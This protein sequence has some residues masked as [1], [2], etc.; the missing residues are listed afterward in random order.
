[1]ARIRV[2]APK[3]ARFFL[4]AGGVSL[5]VSIFMWFPVTAW[6]K[7][8]SAM[9]CGELWYA[10][11][12]IYAAKGYCF[13]TQRARQVFGPRC[14]PPYGRLSGSEQ[15]EVNLIRSFERRRG[16]GRGGTPTPPAVVPPA[17]GQTCDQLWYARNAI[18]AAKGYCFQTAKARRVFGPGCF[19]PYGKLTP[20]EQRRVDAI[21]RQEGLM[22]C[23]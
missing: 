18:Y 22:G 7:P 17:A 12:A 23:R 8:Y 5:F 1:M 13:K 6:A 9:S 14:Y 11:N 4:T 2:P 16:C 15:R 20:A 21:R 19:P 3:I 10:R